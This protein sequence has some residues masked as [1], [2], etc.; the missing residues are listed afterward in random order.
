MLYGYDI[1]YLLF[2]LCQDW[3]SDLS[4]VRNFYITTFTRF[5]ISFFMLYGYFISNT[6][7]AKIGPPPLFYYTLSAESLYN[8]LQSLILKLPTDQKGG[9]T[10]PIFGLW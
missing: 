6:S 4:E 7:N 10:Y 2:K 8:R 5:V 1:T 3:S 9:Q